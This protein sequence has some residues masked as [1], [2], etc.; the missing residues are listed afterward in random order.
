MTFMVIPLSEIGFN[1]PKSFF[2]FLLSF[3]IH[4]FAFGLPIALVA[5]A[6]MRPLI[7]KP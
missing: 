1:P 4:L 3:L 7:A 6:M 5:R 2:L